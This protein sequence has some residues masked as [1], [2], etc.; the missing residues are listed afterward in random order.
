[1]IEAELKARVTDPVA[2]RERLAR[3]AAAEVSVY[4]DTYYDRPDHQ[5]TRQDR[6]LR[7]RVVDTAGTRRTVLTYK[8]PAADAATRSKPEHET[9]VGDA[10]VIDTILL[11]LGLTRLVAFEKHCENYR[12]TAHNREMLATIVTVP[13]IDGVFVELETMAAEADLPA[14]LADVSAVLAELGIT[15]EHLTTELYTEAMMR[16]RA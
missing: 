3:L 1:M 15:A 7:V 2:L 14:A 16:A 9:P 13:E 8:E 10:V 12:F 11:A 6:E 5:L 4:R